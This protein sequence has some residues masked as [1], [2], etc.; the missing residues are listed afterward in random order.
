MYFRADKVNRRYG[1]VG[2]SLG[3]GR[4]ISAL[5][6]V[7]IVRVDRNAYWKRLYRG[8][9]DP[10]DSW[11]GR[12]PPPPGPSG[13]LVSSAVQITAP[14]FGSKL[15]GTVQLAVEAVA[16]GGVA[17]DAYYAT[18]PADRRTL[19]WHALG[20]AQGDG[21]T[22]TLDWNTAAIPSQGN[23][24]WGTINIAATALDRTGK[25]TGTRDYRRCG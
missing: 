20:R 25:R 10:P 9:V 6:K 21:T 12:I 16:V 7:R 18:N 13:P 3:D 19:G 2:L 24:E 1:H 8:W 4:M 14:A 22:W 11:P 5:D 15:G 23:T 17:F